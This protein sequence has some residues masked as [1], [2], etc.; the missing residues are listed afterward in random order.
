MNIYEFP[1]IQLKDTV[2]RYECDSSDWGSLKSTSV[3]VQLTLN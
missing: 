2:N 1:I 3:L